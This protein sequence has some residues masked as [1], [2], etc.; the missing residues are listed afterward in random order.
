MKDALNLFIKHSVD[1]LC[2]MDEQD[3]QVGTLTFKSVINMFDGDV[4]EKN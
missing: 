1:Q 2:V 3:I 4:N